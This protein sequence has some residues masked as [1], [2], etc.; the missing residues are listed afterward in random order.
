[1][2][3]PS[4][5]RENLRNILSAIQATRNAFPTVNASQARPLQPRAQPQAPISLPT[6]FNA[7]FAAVNSL[8]EL[9]SRPS[10]QEAFIAAQKLPPAPPKVAMKRKRSPVENTASLST[11]RPSIHRAEISNV[12]AFPTTTSSGITIEDQETLEKFVRHVNA[13]GVVRLHFWSR[14]KIN[15]QHTDGPQIAKP[16]YLRLTIPDLLVAYLDIAE[17]QGGKKGYQ[18]LLV[19]IF[20]ARERKLPH[21]ATDFSVFVKISQYLTSVLQNHPDADIPTMVDL[22]SSYRELYTEPCMVCGS[23]WSMEG[24]LPPVQRLWVPSQE[25]GE[26]GHWMPRHYLCAR[27]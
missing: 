27:T 13:Q 22:L 15:H 8:E 9:I 20:G 10:T 24:D 14:S 3:T 23:C 17:R 21:C 19:T 26:Q 18:V 6:K 5:V 1:M 12:N 7:A 16:R 2:A 4:D 11:K 25:S